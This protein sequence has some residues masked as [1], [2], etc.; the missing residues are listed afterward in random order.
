M[1]GV[2]DGGQVIIPDYIEFNAL[3][4]ILIE[5]GVVGG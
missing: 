5:V 1:C 3:E 4:S 2:K